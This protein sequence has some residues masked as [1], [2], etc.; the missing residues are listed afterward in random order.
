MSSVMMHVDGLEFEHTRVGLARQLEQFTGIARVEVDPA[1]GT[2][3]VVYDDTRLGGPAAVAHLIAE[4]GYQ[5]VE[6][7]NRSDAGLAH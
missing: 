5:C 7:G 3:T 6:C 2:A 4:C 1:A